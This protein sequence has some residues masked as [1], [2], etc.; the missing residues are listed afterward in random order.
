MART[1]DYASLIQNAG[2]LL[3]VDGENKEYDRG[4]VELVTNTLGLGSEEEDRKAVEEMLR[5]FS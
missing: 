3:S 4:I 1:I 5:T 2:I